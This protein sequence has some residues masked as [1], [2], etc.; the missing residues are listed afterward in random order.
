MALL[1]VVIRVEC[2]IC[3]SILAELE[4]VYSFI[5]FLTFSLVAGLVVG[6][7]GAMMGLGEV[8]LVFAVFVHLPSTSY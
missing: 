8:V 4:V 3:G 7:S 2:E 1:L 6:S 5:T